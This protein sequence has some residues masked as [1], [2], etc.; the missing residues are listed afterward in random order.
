M[1]PGYWLHKNFPKNKR[2]YTDNDAVNKMLKQKFSVKCEE[3][4]EDQYRRNPKTFH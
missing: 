2:K 3:V 1:A 4:K